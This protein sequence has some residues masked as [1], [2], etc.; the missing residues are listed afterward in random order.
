MKGGFFMARGVIKAPFFEIGPKSYL[1][2]DDVLE[3]A[4]AVDRDLDFFL[5][6]T[7]QRKA[8][9]KEEA[10]TFSFYFIWKLSGCV[11][12]SVIDT[13]S[14]CFAS[15]HTSLAIKTRSPILRVS[16]CDASDTYLSIVDS[17][18]PSE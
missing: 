18:S 6:H 4:L 7:Q 16:F 14:P 11:S 10:K 17:K 15:M 1:Y 5:A 12:L 2:G 8:L 3:L 9:R 13:V